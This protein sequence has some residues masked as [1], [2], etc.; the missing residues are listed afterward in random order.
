M[1]SPQQDRNCASMI[2]SCIVARSDARAILQLEPALRREQFVN[3]VGSSVGDFE[4]AHVLIHLV[5][6]SQF[7]NE[8]FA[9]RSNMVAH[10][11]KR[12]EMW[13][14]AL[15]PQPRYFSTPY[16]M[17][18]RDAQGELRV[19]PFQRTGHGGGTQFTSSGGSDAL[20]DIE[21]KA[22]SANKEEDAATKDDAAG[23]DTS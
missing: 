5:G 3:L 18:Y 14:P 10:A 1:A 16:G 11:E 15:E 8:A 21:H 2:G 4:K 20:G 7:Q 22:T 12:R 23:N 19:Q 6:D 13:Y 17:P 9:T